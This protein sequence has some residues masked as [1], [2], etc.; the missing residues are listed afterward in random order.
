MILYAKTIIGK[1]MNPLLLNDDAAYA[2]T[3]TVFYVSDM[4]RKEPQIGNK[5]E[6]VALLQAL[7]T[8]YQLAFNADI[9]GELIIALL[10]L[11]R[12]FANEACV[13][14]AMAS[15]LQDQD[16]SEGF[17]RSPGYVETKREEKKFFD[18]YHTSMVALG[19]MHIYEKSLSRNNTSVE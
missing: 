15:L 4:G 13:K 17:F 7:I 18:N 1:K 16:G 14:L 5:V 2:I 19:A 12:H 6:I 3:H 11:D 9:L 8:Y 10:M